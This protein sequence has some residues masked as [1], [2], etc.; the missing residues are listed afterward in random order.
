MCTSC[1][2]A[3]KLLTA[4]VGLGFVAVQLTDVVLCRFCLC[5]FALLCCC[6]HHELKSRYYLPFILYVVTTKD[7]V[8]SKFLLEVWLPMYAF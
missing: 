8:Y 4:W 7:F 1:G 6:V 3:V 5:F 2:G